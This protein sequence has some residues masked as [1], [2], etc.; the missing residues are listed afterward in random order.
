[1]SQ[2]FDKDNIFKRRLRRTAEGNGNCYRDKDEEENAEGEEET[3]MEKEELENKDIKEMNST[4]ENW[5]T[6]EEKENTNQIHEI[7]TSVSPRVEEKI[8]KQP[9][10][11]FKERSSA[12]KKKLPTYS[13]EAS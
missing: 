10:S 11:P 2:D 3:G 13:N 7:P 8:H 4:K 1:M 5:R 12:N 6:F 9:L